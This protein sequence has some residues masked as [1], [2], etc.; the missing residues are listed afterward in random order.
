VVVLDTAGAVG[1]ND[2]GAVGVPELQAE[3]VKTRATATAASFDV[4][5]LGCVMS[6]HRSLESREITPSSAR[7][8]PP[9]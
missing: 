8:Y 3:Q 7:C 1:D 5:P 6:C 4:W 2:D 9:Q